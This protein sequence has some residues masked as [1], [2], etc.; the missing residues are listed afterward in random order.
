MMR[1]R[2]TNGSYTLSLQKTGEYDFDTIEREIVIDD[3]EQA[4]EM[5]KYM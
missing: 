4:A 3:S 5:L 1:I 2:N